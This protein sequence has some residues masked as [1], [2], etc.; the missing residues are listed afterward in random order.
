[1]TQAQ[2][3]HKLTAAV[4]GPPYLEDPTDLAVRRR[5]SEDVRRLLRASQHDPFTPANWQLTDAQLDEIAEL[6]VT[7]A[8]G[9]F[10]VAAAVWQEHVR[11]L[12]AGHAEAATQQPATALRSS[13]RARSTRAA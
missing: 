13:D 9:T 11:D 4:D 10:A 5:A 8:W 2:D 3:A 6:S 7:A 1:V 12:T